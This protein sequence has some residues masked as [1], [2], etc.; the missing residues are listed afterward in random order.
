M[1]TLVRL[2]I[3]RRRLRAAASAIGFAVSAAVLLKLA[4]SKLRWL[5]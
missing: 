3:L 2:C 5:I 4:A 1:K